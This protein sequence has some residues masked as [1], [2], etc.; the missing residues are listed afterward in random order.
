[1]T[2]RHSCLYAGTVRHRRFL[3]RSHAF[4]YSLY[5]LYLDLDELP[6]L[7]TLSRW[8]STSERWAPVRFRRADHFGSPDIP[9]SDAARDLVEQQAGFRPQGPIRLL[10]Q[11]SHFGYC[12]N[13]ISV[14]YC[15]D[16]TGERVEALIAEVTNT[17]WSDRHC[18]VLDGRKQPLQRQWHDFA[19]QMHVSPFMPMDLHYRWRSRT[20]DAR[21][22]VHLAVLRDDTV[23]LDATLKLERI[24]LH[25]LARYSL[26]RPLMTAQVIAAIHFEAVRLW[27]KGIRIHRRPTSPMSV[28]G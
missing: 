15:F 16:R 17:P 23:M 11:P 3:P 7:D 1:M 22:G 26:R 6:Q 9:L 8:F 10:T 2:S 21:L 20:P 5:M 27:F 19:K 14:F 18:Y 25:R 4:R 28:Q 12:F 13:P 24:P